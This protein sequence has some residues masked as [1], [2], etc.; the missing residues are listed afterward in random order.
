M[1]V[2]LDLH[3]HICEASGFQTPNVEVDLE[4]FCSRGIDA[5]GWGQQA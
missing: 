2:R 4:E 3:T 1:T 5:N